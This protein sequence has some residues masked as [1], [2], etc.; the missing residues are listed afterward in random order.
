[1]FGH[2]FRE[3][4]QRVMKCKHSENRWMNTAEF[5]QCRRMYTFI[6]KLDNISL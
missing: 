6:N 4:T 1:M 3:G 5:E 2:T